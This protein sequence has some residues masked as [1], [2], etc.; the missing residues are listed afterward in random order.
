MDI[1]LSLFLRRQTWV[2]TYSHQILCPVCLSLWDLR[3]AYFST[4]VLLSFGPHDQSM[5]VYRFLITFAF[6]SHRSMSRVIRVSIALGKPQ[7]G[8]F[9]KSGVSMFDARGFSWHSA[10]NYRFGKRSAHTPL[11]MWI[12]FRLIWWWCGKKHTFI[13]N[14]PQRFLR[15]ICAFLGILIG[16]LLQ[17]RFYRLRQLSRRAGNRSGE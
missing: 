7:G 16:T 9:Q 2:Q 6:H 14:S 4:Q 17:A 13:Y 1:F 3:G 11:S 5:Q 12:S 8:T 10:L 15:L